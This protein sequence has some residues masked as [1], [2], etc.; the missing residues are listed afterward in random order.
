[1]SSRRCFKCQG[2]GNITADCPNRKAITLAEWKAIEEQEIKEENKEDIEFNLEETLEE[3]EEEV[4]KGEMLVLRRVLSGQKGAKDEL[5]EYI[6]YAVH[7]L[8]ECLFLDHRWRELCQCS[9]S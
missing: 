6:S 7:S 3:V 2:L 5:R 1:M 4:D 8:R 9:F